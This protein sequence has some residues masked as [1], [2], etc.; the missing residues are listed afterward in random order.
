M[1]VDSHAPDG[2]EHGA[3]H[4]GTAVG[5]DAFDG[6]AVDAER[7][8]IVG[9]RVEHYVERRCAAFRVDI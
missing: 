9:Q 1:A 7:R 4:D 3:G 8:F 6:A 2:D 5:S